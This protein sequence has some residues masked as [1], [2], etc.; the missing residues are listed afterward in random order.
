[1]KTSDF[2]QLIVKMTV[3]E[4]REEEIEKQRLYLATCLESKDGFKLWKENS[5]D[6]REI[7]NTVSKDNSKKWYSL[8]EVGQIGKT[9]N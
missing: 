8:E 7:L 3:V 1:M 5:K 9:N 2:F 4:A 6:N